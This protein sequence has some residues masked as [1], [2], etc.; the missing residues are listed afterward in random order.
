MAELKEKRRTDIGD[1]LDRMKSQKTKN[2]LN[3]DK[4]EM[5]LEARSFLSDL[6]NP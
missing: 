1:R 4:K 6:L 2:N 5:E 3:L